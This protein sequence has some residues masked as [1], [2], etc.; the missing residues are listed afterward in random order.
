YSSV[1]RAVGSRLYAAL[2]GSPRAELKPSSCILCISQGLVSSLSS[3]LERSLMAQ[4]YDELAHYGGMD[5]VGVPASM[6]GDPHA[7][8]PLPQVHHLNHGPPLHASQ[9]YGAHAPHP[10][11]MPT[12]MGS[13]VNDVLKRDKDQIYGHPLFP[14]LALVFEKCEL[15]TCTP[16]EPGVAGGDV[17]S[18]D[19]FNEDIAV[20]AK[21]VR[22]EKP[23]FSSNPEL[24][25]LM[26]QAIQV[27]RFHLLELEKV[28]ELCD[29]FC[30]R[31]ISCL[32]GKMPIDLVIDER[33]GSSKSD[34]EELSGSSTNLADHNPASW[35]DHDD[36]TSTHSAGTPGPSSGGHA[37]QSGDNS[38]EQGLAA[39]PPWTPM[40]SFSSFMSKE[41]SGGDGEQA[42]LR[43]RGVPLCRGAAPLCCGLL[44]SS[45]FATVRPDGNGDPPGRGASGREAGAK[46]GGRSGKKRH[47][48]RKT[49]D[50]VKRI[51][52]LKK[53][54]VGLRTHPSVSTDAPRCHQQSLSHQ[55]LPSALTPATAE[56]G[57]AVRGRVPTGR[58]RFCRKQAAWRH[59]PFPYC[60]FF[61]PTAPEK[62]GD[63][64]DNSVASP[65]TGDDD[66]PD[67]DKKRQKKRGIFPKVA[68][69]IMRA[70]LFQ[71][72]TSGPAKAR[73]GAAMKTG[74]TQIQRYHSRDQASWVRCQAAS[75]LV[76]LGSAAKLQSQVYCSPGLTEK[77]VIEPR[78]VS[79]VY[80]RT[81]QQMNVPLYGLAFYGSFSAGCHGQWV[82]GNTSAIHEPQLRLAPCE[83]AGA[84][85]STLQ[86]PVATQA[87][88]Q[89]NTSSA[90]VRACVFAPQL[91][92]LC[93]WLS[94]REPNYVYV[95]VYELVMRGFAAVKLIVSRGCRAVAFLKSLRYGVIT[96]AAG[97]L[98][99]FVSVPVLA[100][101]A[102]RSSDEDA[103]RPCLP[104]VPCWLLPPTG[105]PVS[106]AESRSIDK[107]AHSSTRPRLFLSLSFDDYDEVLLLCRTISRL[108]GH[109]TGGDEVPQFVV[110]SMQPPKRFVLL[111]VP[112]MLRDA[113]E[114]RHVCCA[115]LATAA[116]HSMRACADE[117]AC[118]IVSPPRA[119]QPLREPPPCTGKNKTQSDFALASACSRLPIASPVCGCPHATPPLPR[120]A[121][122]DGAEGG[123]SSQVDLRYPRGRVTVADPVF[124]RPLSA[125]E[126]GLAEAAV[127]SGYS[128]ARVEITAQ[129]MKTPPPQIQTQGVTGPIVLVRAV[130]PLCPPPPQGEGGGVWVVASF[131]PA[132]S[133]DKASNK[134]GASSQAGRPGQRSAGLGAGLSRR[135]SPFK[136]PSTAALV[137]RSERSLRCLSVGSKSNRLSGMAFPTDIPDRRTHATADRPASASEPW[138]LGHF[139]TGNGDSGGAWLSAVTQPF[140]F[141]TPGLGLTAARDNGRPS[142]AGPL[143]AHKQPAPVQKDA[144]AKIT[145][146]GRT[147]S[148]LSGLSEG[149]P[150]LPCKDMQ[151]G[152][153]SL[154]ELAG[155]GGKGSHEPDL[156]IK[157]PHRYGCGPERRSAAGERLTSNSLPSSLPLAQTKVPQPLAAPCFSPD[158]LQPRLAS[159]QTCFS[160]DLLQPR[161]ASAQTCFSPDLLQPRL[162][163][164]QTCFSPDLLQPRLASAQT[165][166]SPDLLQPRPA[167]TQT[168]FSPD[169]LQPR[170][171][172]AQTC[173]SPD[174]LQ[175]RPASAQ[176][177]FSPDLLQPRPASTQT[178]FN[179]DLLQPRPAS[180][181]SEK[182]K[183]SR[184]ES[185]EQAA[186]E[187][188]FQHPYP[189]EEQKKQ[190]AQDT[191]LTILQVNNWLLAHST[192]RPPPLQ[193]ADVFLLY[194]AVPVWCLVPGPNLSPLHCG[195]GGH[196]SNPTTEDSI[197]QQSAVV[198]RSGHVLHSGGVG[199]NR[200]NGTRVLT[201][202]PMAIS[203][204]AYC[205]QAVPGTS[206]LP[207][208]IEL[209]Q[210]P[211]P[212]PPHPMQITCAYE[213]SS[214][215][216]INA[217]RRIVQPMIDQSNRAG[218]AIV[219]PW[220][221]RSQFQSVSQGAA[222]SP[223]GQPMGSF[224]LDGQQHM[225][226]RPAG[227]QSVP[228]EYVLQS[229]PVGISMAPLPY[230]TSPPA[231]PMP[232]L[233]QLRHGPP[234]HPYLSGQ[235]SPHAA[236][237]MHGGPH[238]HPGI[239]MSAQSPPILTPIDHSTG[240]QGLDIHAQ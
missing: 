29:N 42:R 195:A 186:E 172:P 222:Y 127:S 131:L 194:V 210:Y 112:K 100:E 175:P 169:L 36:A 236:M 80:G 65:G 185:Q 119:T 89:L 14:L 12:S 41:E 183:N 126:G 111:R 145:M 149:S 76:C 191:G 225:G 230:H 46:K 198:D 240:G 70:W 2:L 47:E 34:H 3:L 17:C 229:A 167:S 177:C 33:D 52:A 227:L 63:G 139:M 20:F 226:I 68:T 213:Y 218:K 164:A 128:A 118:G 132:L 40:R 158:L 114:P 221:L 72:L 71:H 173:F 197:N 212:Y 9:H 5:G 238:G 219:S 60:L 199:K 201:L 35:R 107:H 120:T 207:N 232:H 188:H 43:G 125:L 200:T 176:T 81:L 179:P 123:R 101:A 82:W 228:R 155:R 59:P 150:A 214:R 45:A 166:F 19:S 134:R 97:L 79:E 7:P 196:A 174:L 6:Y 142:A 102:P 24:D 51:K 216:F 58:R 193:S 110:V 233:P 105:L 160:P 235:P 144:A 30:H 96:P 1:S 84:Q 113:L 136:S 62:A 217:R 211:M 77:G 27:L 147:I 161:L 137:S 88:V 18:S 224:V 91:G 117:H 156:M 203:E 138:P 178:C 189:S 152:L 28:H 104:A 208:R 50:E 192:S 141:Y 11:V 106:A 15:A 94:T 85:E 122:S 116:L 103:S 187:L 168:C 86:S 109:I 56:H 75:L 8:R 180:S 220:F 39:A 237:L 23:L 37:S 38:S 234:L 182:D 215:W 54:R 223:E 78:T 202:Y 73:V 154:K 22:A 31:Y 44:P 148:P 92:C 181:E 67:K 99:A 124:G 48:R 21:Q 49:E 32:K 171:A 108:R 26:I 25:N 16:R 231:P 115:A 130:R 90:P 205:Y 69:N 87:T 10:N 184:R 61:F 204:Q 163:S 190:L 55:P 170:P 159:A 135:A 121:V 133:V 140:H 239:P 165:C 93:L 129:S 57:A 153:L 53:L 162:A 98:W 64:L 146:K 66:D 151:I 13:A 83:Q 209:H 74:S 4:R 157:Q 206:E 95:R 143:V